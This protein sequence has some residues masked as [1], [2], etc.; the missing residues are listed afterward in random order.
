MDTNDTAQD[1]SVLNRLS[2]LLEYVEHTVRLTEKPI[3]SVREHRNLCYFERQLQG[4]IGVHHDAMDHAGA[5]WL[6]N[7]RLQRADPPEV[8]ETL[9]PWLEV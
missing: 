5:I 8:P 7:D 6:K 9:R 3:F 2:A 1:L 4:R